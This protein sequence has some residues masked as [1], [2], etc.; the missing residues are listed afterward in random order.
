MSLLSQLATKCPELC[1][2]S[3]PQIRTTGFQAFL[4]VLWQPKGQKKTGSDPERPEES[5][6]QMELPSLST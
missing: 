6:M 1:S 4:A 5:P 3:F 2:L